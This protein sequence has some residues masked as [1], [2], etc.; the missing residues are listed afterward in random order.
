MVRPPLMKG[1]KITR[2]PKFLFLLFPKEMSFF[3]YFVVLIFIIKEFLDYVSKFTSLILF[4]F[5]SLFSFLLYNIKEKFSFGPFPWSLS[6]YS[7]FSPDPPSQETSP[8]QRCN[9]VKGLVEWE[10]IQVIGLIW[11]KSILLCITRE[12]SKVP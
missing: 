3:A 7:G 4:K 10:R 2:R 8:N 12:Q 5:L 1:W 9:E 6:Y 11:V